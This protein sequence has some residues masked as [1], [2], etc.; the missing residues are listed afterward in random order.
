MDTGPV[1]REMLHEQRDEVRGCP[2]DG[3]DIQLAP[4]DLV[5]AGEGGVEADLRRLLTLAPVHDHGCCEACV[6]Q[7][8]AGDE[9]LDLAR[10]GRLREAPGVRAARLPELPL[11]VPAA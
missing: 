3:R 4:A 11:A 9:P 8:A 1:A 10:R 2:G 6:K 5:E 7:H